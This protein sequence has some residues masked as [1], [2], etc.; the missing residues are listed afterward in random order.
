MENAYRKTDG[1]KVSRTA[2]FEAACPAQVIIRRR[3]WDD[4]L[5][6]KIDS[7]LI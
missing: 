3:F 7:P 1:S 5:K 6:G 2:V 4:A